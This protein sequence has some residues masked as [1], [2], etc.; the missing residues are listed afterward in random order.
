[1]DAIN[2][3]ARLMK[4][5]ASNFAFA[6]T[7]DRR[8]AT[9][10]RISI[11]RQRS[12][13]VIWLNNRLPGVKVGDFVHSKY[14]L[15]LGQHGGNEFVIVLKNCQPLGAEPCSLEQRIKK[16]QEAVEMGL[17][18]LRARGYINYYGLQRFG[19]HAISTHVLG[20]K[21]LSGDFEGV[22]EDILHVEDHLVEQVLNQGAQPSTSA[23]ND[24][25]ERARA[26]T[27]WKMTKNVESALTHL[28]KRFSTESAIMRHLGAATHQ[29]DFMG[30]LLSIT[31]GMRMMYIHAYQSYVWNHV[32]SLRWS[33]YGTT[34]I[35]GDLV[36]MD[37]NGRSD[38]SDNDDVAMEEEE[39]YSRARH[40]T[41]DD[42]SSGKYT[43]ADVVLPT[44]GFDVIYPN[45]D[46][47]DFYKE[48]MARAENGS[49]NPFE[50]RRKQ[51]E[52][53]LSGNYRTLL[54]YFITDPKYCIRTYTNDTEQMYPT[55]LDICTAKKAAHK[56]A[57]A[58]KLEQDRLDKTKNLPLWNHFASNP[59]EWDKALAAE[60]RRKAES[61]EPSTDATRTRETWVQTGLD[62]RESKRVKLTRE[63][64]ERIEA[65]E[66]AK[67][68]EKPA[69]V[70]P[71]VVNAEND[72]AGTEP[73]QA[74]PS[75]TAAVYG[76]QPGE[77]ATGI[78]PGVKGLADLLSNGRSAQDPTGVS[79][80][81]E[82]D[83]ATKESST[84][85]ETKP[86][87]ASDP[88]NWFGKN[89]PQVAGP[90][91]VVEAIEEAQSTVSDANHIQGVPV[92][93]LRT[94]SGNQ[95]MALD[96]KS[97]SDEGIDTSKGG[98]KIAVVLK[99]QL[100]SSNYATVVL[101]ELTGVPQDGSA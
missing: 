59:A 80:T 81:A 57:A 77:T 18:F 96:S 1:M 3:I 55:D 89:M 86:Q 19:T 34:V 70:D 91:P 44:P 9:V 36:L 46:I 51:R 28:P 38:G 73:G 17:S 71:P 69:A 78:S 37:N 99:F 29:R 64:F 54:G 95:L 75:L 16:I 67:E 23:P 27:T 85:E 53:S 94:V 62:E 56:V 66:T 47:G 42:I 12:Q 40:L 7:K 13:N 26:I 90:E 8:A 43:I 79:V 82:E 30:A 39:F 84:T 50:M 31:R 25:F 63:T 92:P 21:I 49:L 76:S 87:T 100:K 20:M 93:A 45:N 14:P 83:S 11:G 2:T 32:A 24:E 4:I 74:V 72:I 58:K 41:A 5:K 52:F 10:Q 97:L 6:G 33:K 65:P 48:F 22:I 68:N 15:S 98:D 101:R 35:A 88:L 60:R 61:E